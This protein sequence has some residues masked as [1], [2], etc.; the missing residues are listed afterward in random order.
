MAL[1]E[2]SWTPRLIVNDISTTSVIYVYFRVKKRQQTQRLSQAGLEWPTNQPWNVWLSTY[3]QLHTRI[4]PTLELALKGCSC[5][6]GNLWTHTLTGSHF[7]Q[8]KVFVGS[9]E[10][11]RARHEITQCF[12]LK[13]LALLPVVYQIRGPEPEQGLGLCSVLGL[14]IILIILITGE[15]RTRHF[16]FALQPASYVA[17]LTPSLNPGARSVRGL[18]T[19]GG[20]LRPWVTGECLD[21]ETYILPAKQQCSVLPFITVAPHLHLLFPHLAAHTVLPLPGEMTTTHAGVKHWLFWNQISSVL[22]YWSLLGA[23]WRGVQGQYPWL[24]HGTQGQWL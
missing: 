9:A 17:V 12:C 24:V 13:W 23:S 1:A 19:P 8:H 22:M 6:A 15:Q 5:P 11:C 7:L 2:H 18:Q 21:H 16:N 3:C 10:S 20:T 4:S 14:V